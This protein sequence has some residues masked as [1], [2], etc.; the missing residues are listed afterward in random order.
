MRKQCKGVI[1]ATPPYSTGYHHASSRADPNLESLFMPSLAPPQLV[2]LALLPQCRDGQSPCMHA[3]L[4]HN[5][6]VLLDH[7]QG[8]PELEPRNV[9]NE[10]VHRER[11]QSCPDTCMLMRRLKNRNVST[12]MLPTTVRHSS[13]TKH[14]DSPCRT[15]N[16]SPT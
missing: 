3:S 2:L 10:E 14:W 9:L 6:P 1:H 11:R 8:C 13:N 15:I 16:V 4:P 7:G 5:P 12:P